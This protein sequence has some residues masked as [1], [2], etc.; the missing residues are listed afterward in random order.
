MVGELSTF[1]QV[2]PRGDDE[3]G[4]ALPPEPL[5]DLQLPFKVGTLQD[6]QQRAHITQDG[7]PEWLFS[8]AHAF[9]GIG[10]EP[11]RFLRS[12]KAAI[13]EELQKVQVPAQQFHYR[14]TGEPEAGDNS[15]WKDHTFESRA[16]FVVLL[17]LTRTRSLKAQ[18]KVKTLNLILGLAAKAFSVMD[19]GKP[20]MG[21]V[22]KRDGTL[23]SRELAFSKQGVCLSFAEFIMLC[24][25]ASALWKKLTT[26]CWLNRCIT[27]S[28]ETI[29]FLDLWFFV[30][31]IY[32]HPKLKQLGQNL[33]S[34]IGKDLL[35]ELVHRTGEALVT[36]AVQ[37]SSEALS[38]LP[39]LKT[40][41]GAVRK[42]ADPVNRMLLLL[43][44][45][46]EKQHRKRIAATHEEL[47]GS[48]NRMIV[49]ENYVDCI[50]HLKA[51]QSGFER[52]KQVS[53]SWDP[54]NYGGKEILM[55]I[56]YDPAFDKAAY[57]MC[58]HMTQ[59][60]L[61][62]LH[63][64]LLPAAKSRKLCRLEGFKEL[65]GLG[66][67]LASVG[68]SLADFQVPEGLLC[69]P[70]SSQEFRLQG[71][72]GSFWRK[73]VATNVLSPEIPLGMDLGQVACLVS[74]TDQGP[75][76]IGATNYLQYSPSAL[77]FL[78]LWDPFH[79]AWND[80]KGAMK[81]SKSGAWRTVL[82]L[83]LVA[84][85]NY[86]PFSSS[87]WHYKKKARLEDFCATRNC[88]DE[89]WVKYQHLICKERR[90]QEPSSFDDCQALFETLHTL[91]S[92][93]TKGPLIKLMR[94]FSWFES[95]VFYQGELWMTKMVLESG[96][97]SL[98]QGSEQEVDEKP[99]GNKDHQ[100]ELQELKKRKG[101]WKLAPQLINSK[102]MAVKDCILSIGKSTWQ[103]F[104]ARARDICSPNHVMELNIS[105]S[106]LGFW[107]QELEEMVQCSLF[108]ERHM[109]HLLPEFRSH[110]KVLEWHV[111][112]MDRL[113]QTRTQSLVAFHCLPPNLYNH[114]L[115]PS[116]AAVVAASELATGHWKV[117]LKAEEAALAG[118]E[119]KPL[120]SMHWRLNPLVRTLLMAY[121]EDAAKGRLFSI[122]SAALR[123]QRVIAKNL[124]DSRVIENIHQ[125][126]RDLYRASKAKTIS[127]TAIMAN[128]LR[129][130]VL[131]QRKVPMVNA[132]EAQK[133]FGEAWRPAYKESVVSSMRS[134]GKK[135][136][137]GLQNLMLAQKGDH[138][139]PSPAAGSLFQ[140]AMATQWLFN[141]WGNEDLPDVDVNAAWL[142]FLAQPGSILAQKS[143]GLMVK[144]LAS[145]E[146]GFVGLRMKVVVLDQKRFYCCC[147]GRDQF[148]TH[149]I[150]DLDDW[151][152]LHTEPSLLGGHT[153]PIGWVPTG[154]APLPLD[155]SALA[156]GHSMTFQQALGLLRLYG[157][158]GGLPGNPS[159]ATVMKKLIETVVPDNLKEQALSHL[160]AP[161]AKEEQMFDS[162]FSEVLSELGQ[163]ENNI[164]DLKEYKEKK[165]FYNMKR[166][167]NAKDSPIPKAKAKG[168]A[169]AKATA[170]PKPKAKAKDFATRFSNRRAKKLAE[171]KKA[172][173]EAC[174]DFADGLE[175][176]LDE[177]FPQQELEPEPIVP[178]A[179]PMEVEVAE[180][181]PLE[182]EVAE[183]GPMEV[184]EAPAGAMEV[185]QEAALVAEAGEAADAK[186]KAA[187]RREARKTP[188]ELM[189]LIEPPGCKM[190]ISFN[191]H[192]FTSR[193]LQDHP[194]LPGQFS[195]RTFSRAFFARRSWRDALVDVH[196]HNWKKW[197]QLKS[198]YP[199]AGKREMEPGQIPDHILDQFEP[200]IAE[201]PEYVRYHEK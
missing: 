199:L 33:W 41:A 83:T 65:K 120:K 29:S 103:L 113:L 114:I 49:F 72:D 22:T 99:K 123:L 108:D 61:S 183:A 111:D 4:G 161:Q 69:R 43:K 129:S 47:G 54:S 132:H 192:T 163:D 121:E 8:R 152:E 166:R 137:V 14:G 63:P 151:I 84:N 96:L 105:C 67:A 35:V 13:E 15:Q 38:M 153:G 52:S 40:K 116:P 125:H 11:G 197:R 139:W 10:T 101:T 178:E 2:V 164:Q 20:I 74:V 93:N 45:K 39:T 126:G 81:A 136:P 138:T 177:A 62:E 59:T 68:L 141:Y 143:S 77:M 86:G 142:S 91:D 87:A 118:V 6:L 55:S 16:F 150:H 94:W 189:A 191:V 97:D 107:K 156:Q 148:M 98:E 42:V 109:Q 130:G 155:V 190:G 27:S 170:K 200:I 135:M 117:L 24:P 25:G 19:L 188:E 179:G 64:S 147:Q 1:G 58:Q 23:V 80:L 145:A 140:S 160:Q 146:F 18:G 159:K 51:L 46:K 176:A 157:A 122:D 92:F 168:K 34:S 57:L 75:N 162:D 131:E 171:D 12:N 53:V 173:E 186:A 102:N 134:K 95:M 71:K 48:T 90:M 165:K 3:E 112:L 185:G 172:E 88:S 70:L 187:P 128:C 106:Y 56:L 36:V 149:Y 30:V 104:A 180:A 7:C 66:S 169:K 60:M 9:C 28:V 193:W 127:N 167:M 110:E 85:L 5:Q 124:G 195:Q 194:S 89:L 73:H 79:R 17:L 175:K 82:E 133:A 78:A 44:L 196:E 76:I 50:L 181:E 198:V 100:K 115:S 144:V 182:G 119:V 37:A 26:R 21:L 31:Y 32:A 158:A 184:E 154:H 201:L 174:L